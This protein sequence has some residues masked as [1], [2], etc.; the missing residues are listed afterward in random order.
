MS[1][2]LIPEV[3][4][5]DAARRFKLLSETVR[6]ELINELHLNG[7]MSVQQLVNATGHQQANVSK[8]LLLM[9]REGLLSRRRKGLNVIYALND[10][11]VSGMC[12]LAMASIEWANE[13][14]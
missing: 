1:R 6:L 7:E 8:H 9:A 14:A 10:P 3:H 11:S 4:L 13:E 5:D 12:L 2:R